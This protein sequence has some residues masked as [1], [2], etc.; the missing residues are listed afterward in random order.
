MLIKCHN[1]AHLFEAFIQ[2]A[3]QYNNRLPIHL[4]GEVPSQIQRSHFIM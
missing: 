1:T 2:S 3:L 4:K